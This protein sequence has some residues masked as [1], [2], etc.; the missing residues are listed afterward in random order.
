MTLHHSTSAIQSFARYFARPLCPACGE[1]LLAPE[2]SEFAG[3]GVVHHVW[4]CDACGHEFHTT[5]EFNR[6]AA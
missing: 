4:A 5:V 3:E 6:E 1:T 2:Q